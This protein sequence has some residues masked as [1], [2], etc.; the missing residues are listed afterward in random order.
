MQMIPNTNSDFTNDFE[1]EEPSSNTFKLDISGNKVQGYT[2][3]LEA[4]K[5]AI[6]LILNTERYEYLIFS[7]NY[8]IELSDLFGKSVKFVMVELERRIK[9]ALL[10]DNRIKSVEN[11]ETTHKRNKVYCTFKVV[12]IYGDIEAE[13]AVNV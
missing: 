11:F 13:R 9:E 3:N 2:D 1:F 6:Y 12:T 4:M 8:G 7:W 5:Q 10:Q